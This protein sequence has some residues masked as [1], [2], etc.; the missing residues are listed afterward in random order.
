[1]LE[2]QHEIGMKYRKQVETPFQA[3]DRA[4]P[5]I[6]SA[7]TFS[8]DTIARVKLT[9]MVRTWFTYIKDNQIQAQRLN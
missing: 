8:D 6:L 7:P 1:M 5:Q 3:I 4:N 2:V 9:I